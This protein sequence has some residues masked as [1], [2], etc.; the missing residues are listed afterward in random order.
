MNSKK[1][2][3]PVV[4][5]ALLLVVAVG[6]T[7]S[8]N[9]W[10][11]EYMSSI[12]SK[13]DSTNTGGGDFKIV[14]FTKINETNG[15]LYLVSNSIQFIDFVKINNQICNLVNSD[16]IDT[17]MSIIE[18]SNCDLTN[19]EKDIKIKTENAIITKTFYLK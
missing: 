6:A 15:E 14:S 3:G 2:I 11:T 1:G 18:I 13:I 9:T 12:F 19:G 8:F 10:N 17:S 16:V 4:A 5:I 7:L